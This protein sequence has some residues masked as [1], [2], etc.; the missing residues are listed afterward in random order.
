[1]ETNEGHQGSARKKRVSI[2]PY[3]A[4]ALSTLVFS[5]T[6]CMVLSSVSALKKEN[7]ALRDDV[8]ALRNSVVTDREA[9]KSVQKQA[10]DL[11]AELD[12]F[13]SLLDK[14]PA[15]QGDLEMIKA[16]SASPG[17]K[18]DSFNLSFFSDADYKYQSYTGAGSV[19]CDDA[20][21]S[22]LALLRKTLKSGG[23]PTTK[24]VEYVPILVVGGA[25]SFSTDDSA[26]GTVEKPVYEFEIVGYVRMTAAGQGA[27]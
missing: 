20:Q 7:A 13:R 23:A 27:G 11:R 17:F 25:G 14:I 6:V 26:E 4:M 10:E 5:L 24:P 12:G 21:G 16:A 8:A 3:V 15:L 9:V 18:V 22:Y 2:A 1:M 19:R